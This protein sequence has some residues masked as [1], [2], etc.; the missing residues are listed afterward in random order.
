M[1]AM[2]KSN[3]NLIKKIFSV[4]KRKEK[5]IKLYEHES[6]Y[7]YIRN[8]D[9]ILN[10]FKEIEKNYIFKKE[11]IDTESLYDISKLLANLLHDLREVFDLKL[12][13]E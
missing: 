13:D 7:I 12:K 8:I 5:K 4:F 11:S 6:K 1:V 3:N 9:V 10:L 2:K